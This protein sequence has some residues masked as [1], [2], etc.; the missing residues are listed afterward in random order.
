MVYAPLLLG[1][2]LHPTWRAK[3]AE[4]LAERNGD[5]APIN[6]PC[7]LI[8]AVSV[9][10]A[11]ATAE[12]IRRL[13][14]EQD[15]LNVVVSTTTTTGFAHVQRLFGEEPR[16]RCVRFPLD[17]SKYVRRFLDRLRPSVV[18]L[19]E[20]EVWPN[21]IGE[22]HRR[23]IP[24]L[25]GN[26]RMTTK[27]YKGYR[28]LGP[29]AKPMFRKIDRVLA[30]EA[31]YAERFTAVGCP[32]VEVVG[33]MKF[34]TA[35]TEAPEGVDELLEVMGLG[36]GPVWVCGSTGPGEETIVLDAYRKLLEQRPALRLVIVPRHPQRFEEVAGIIEKTGFS[37]SRRTTP[38]DNP[39]AVILGDTMG[40]LRK[41][42]AL[43]DVVL[44]GRTLVDLG[45]SQRGSDMIEPAALGRHVV[46]GPWTQNFAAAMTAFKESRAIRTVVGKDGG[47]P[48]AIAIMAAVDW[49]LSHDDDFALRARQVVLEQ[50]GA[51]AKHVEA[52]QAALG[53][54]AATM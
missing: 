36:D 22:C 18:M 42:Y 15:E 20:L 54:S 31:T 28:R 5:V 8:H 14:A 16:V 40:E 27:S 35:S 33:S 32:N 39:Q 26:G 37:L 24:V 3:A 6:G 11:A 44:V 51:T 53:S 50:R 52:L 21:F 4:A 43:A 25:V 30:Q 29:L 13:L 9:G 1:A 2:K 7:V 23:G 19:M 45:V 17:L 49:P 10:E 46:V 47:T 12:L 41:W 38:V 48:S 34:D